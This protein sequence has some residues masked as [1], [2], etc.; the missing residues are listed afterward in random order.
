MRDTGRVK[1]VNEDFYAIVEPEEST[2]AEARGRLYVV[3]DGMGNQG[4]GEV[5]AKTA[6]DTVV[7]VY[8]SGEGGEN[9][10]DALRYAVECAHSSIRDSAQKNPEYTKM[11]AT[12]T[13]LVLLDDR[14]FIA[15]VGDTRAYVIRKGKIRQLTDD[16]NWAG[17]QLR[18]GAI[19]KVHANTHPR[20]KV[21]TR[22]LGQTPQVEIDTMVAEIEPGD[23]FLLCTDGLYDT[24]SDEEME[25][26]LIEAGPEMACRELVARANRNGGADNIAAVLI[27][28]VYEGKPFLIK[29]RKPRF[30]LGDLKLT[31]NFDWRKKLASLPVGLPFYLGVAAVAILVIIGGGMLFFRGCGGNHEPSSQQAATGSHVFSQKNQP[32]KIKITTAPSGAI[33]AVDGA[34]IGPSPVAVDLFP[35]SHEIEI[36]QDGYQTKKHT[37]M[38]K[39]GEIQIPLNFILV[40]HPAE[41]SPDMLFIPGGFFIMGR[42]GGSLEEGPSHKIYLDAYYI[43]RYEVSNADYKRFIEAA[44]R[45]APALFEDPQKNT[46]NLPVA[47]VDW[48]DADAYCSWAK[49]RLPTEAEWEKAARGAEGWLYPWGNT[50]DPTRA[51]ILGDADG[52]PDVAPVDALPTGK[53]PYGGYNFAGNV[54]EWTGG[55]FDPEYYKTIPLKNPRGPETGTRRVVRGGSY[56]TAPETAT[57]TYRSAFAPESRKPYIG[58]RCAK[59]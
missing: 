37:L 20:R 56:R 28:T 2:E 5:A 40:P 44:K 58:F 30:Q 31:L 59:D 52:Y 15:H 7:D 29:E 45:A 54:G 8:Y 16:H 24:L 14:V 12:L 39:P 51:N 26:V 19:T 27:K 32:A 18:K 25:R 47:G 22:S 6:V 3:A 46:P 13:A 50:F 41:R 21:L 34:R 35:G 36:T 33:I 9:P 4:A 53:S 38:V 57:A 55:Y 10:Q 11:G 17:D 23:I 49:K 1:E 48:T 43:D 42:E